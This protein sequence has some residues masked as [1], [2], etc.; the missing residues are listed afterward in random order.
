MGF[1][2]FVFSDLNADE[3]FN[4][5]L[6]NQTLNERV[7]CLEFQ[8]S[9]RSFDFSERSAL[10]FENRKSISTSLSNRIEFCLWLKGLEYIQQKII[11]GDQIQFS[12]IIDLN[13]LIT[14]NHDPIRNGEV[15]SD[16]GY[17]YMPHCMLKSSMEQ[18]DELIKRDKFFNPLEKAGSIRYWIATTHLFKD[19]NGRTANL[20]CDWILISNNILPLSFSKGIQNIYSTYVGWEHRR[21]RFLAIKKTYTSVLNSYDIFLGKK[22]DYANVLQ[23]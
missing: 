19:A 6:F 9:K 20:V 2:E 18:M 14:K 12:N 15:Y 11:S 10:L 17:Q 7:K 21:N 4:I 1:V 3:V 5:R 23:V 8:G 13:A 16:R 22:T